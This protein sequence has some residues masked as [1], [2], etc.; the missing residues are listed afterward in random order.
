MCL[1]VCLGGMGVLFNMYMNCLCKC[2]FLPSW[3][4]WKLIKRNNEIK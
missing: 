3:Y 2:V 4:E 1:C